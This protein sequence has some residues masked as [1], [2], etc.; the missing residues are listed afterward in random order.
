MITGAGI[1]SEMQQLLISSLNAEYTDE[2]SF[3][4][5]N[6]TLL[7]CDYAKGN[8]MSAL[9]AAIAMELFATAADIF[10]DIQ[11]QDNDELP[12]RKISNAQ[13]LN[14]G[15]CFLMLSDKALSAV[16][17]PQLYRLSKHVLNQTG[18][19]ACDGQF[20]ETL[21]E[22][23]SRISL[24]QYFELV[25]QKSGALMSCAFQLGALFAGVSDSV[26]NGFGQVGIYY[27]IMN[28]IRNDLRDFLN[29]SKKRDF[30][31]NTKT[32]PFTYLLSVLQEEK[33]VR[34]SHLAAKARQGRGAFGEKEQND[35][36]RLFHEEGVTPYCQVMYEKFKQKV[37]GVMEEFPADAV[38]KEKMIKLVV[39]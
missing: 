25:E 28:Q 31:N 14:L 6:F 34:F 1:N 11:D 32:L 18:L 7:A 13:A 2:K 24:Q 23:S 4:W 38:R 15:L 9:S 29:F 37:L 20:R 33:A 3:R 21:Y 22:E 19:V 5:A 12:W 35:V 26:L 10:D 16:E 36:M 30:F 8:T 27:G 17:D 39:E